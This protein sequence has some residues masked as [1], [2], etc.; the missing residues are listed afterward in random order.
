MIRGPH[1]VRVRRYFVTFVRTTKTVQYF[2]TLGLDCM[3]NKFQVNIF[4]TE[5][6]FQFQSQP[7]KNVLNDPRFGKDPWI[8]NFLCMFVPL[9]TLHVHTK[10]EV[11]RS[12]IGRVIKEK[13]P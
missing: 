3:H 4:E 11:N 1:V 5:I 12:N 10:F 8:P 13:V 7:L 2:I 6:L 9:C